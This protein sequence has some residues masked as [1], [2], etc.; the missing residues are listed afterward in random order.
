MK[1][2]LDTAS[3][4]HI[5]QLKSTGLIDGVTTNPTHLS[6]EG[7]NPRDVVLAICDILPHGEIS[8]EITEKNP[9]AVY[10]QAKEIAA[11]ASNILV[12][13]PCHKDYYGVIHQL[14]KDGIP[15]NIT[16]VFSLVQA[17]FMAK[18][19]V[20]Y[21]SPFVG[22][23]E[24]TKEDGIGLIYA[25]R[26]AFNHYHFET[27]ILSASI[28]NSNHVRDVI[29]AGTDAITIPITL[30]PDLMQHPLT[31]KGMEL[32]DADW[33]KLDIKKFP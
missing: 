11:L 29:L 23:L 22:R 33:R 15:L 7:K 3:I 26:H 32:F 31:D 18:L 20:R 25:I 4:E 12:K 28:R 1:I 6:K 9:D 19:G 14:V 5:T 30:L 24:D 2:F 27:G 21:V 13:V 10:K 8:V 16:L 17:V